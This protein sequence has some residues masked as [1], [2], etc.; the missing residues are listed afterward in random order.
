LYGKTIISII[1]IL[2][3][4]LFTY[5]FL[6]EEKWYLSLAFGIII[7]GAIGNTI[8]RIKFGGVI[9][10]LDFYIK[11]WHYPIFNT[12]DCLIFIGGFILIFHDL[13]KKKI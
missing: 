9:D 5:L 13:F 7:A 4:I 11:N 12:A 2:I 3:I 6:K 8:D 10:F 1:V